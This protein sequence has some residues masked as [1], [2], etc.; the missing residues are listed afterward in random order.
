MQSLREAYASKGGLSELLQ[1]I[2]MQESELLSYIRLETSILRFV[3]FRF[4]PFIRISP[5]EIEAYYNER[6]TPQL[7][8]AGVALPPLEQVSEKIRSIL[9]EEKINDVLDQWIK[10]IRRNSRIEYFHDPK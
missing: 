4:R 5:E 10:E 6:L 3:D 1:R 8:G 9:R 7:Q 2:G